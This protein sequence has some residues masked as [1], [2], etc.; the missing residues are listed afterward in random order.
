MLLFASNPHYAELKL[1]ELMLDEKEKA[2]EPLR[3][4]SRERR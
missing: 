1:L 2:G 4:P 3:P